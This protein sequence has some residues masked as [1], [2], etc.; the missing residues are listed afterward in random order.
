MLSDSAF[1]GPLPLSRVA[2]LELLDR[3]DDFDATG[4]TFL[5][6]VMIPVEERI[7]EYRFAGASRSLAE[8]VRR[9]EEFGDAI[10]L[11]QPESPRGLLRMLLEDNPDEGYDSE[12]AYPRE[13][14][15][16]L[17]EPHRLVLCVQYGAPY[18]D[19]GACVVEVPTLAGSAYDGRPPE[20][21]F[22]EEWREGTIEWVLEEGVKRFGPVPPEVEVAI[23]A[24]ER[25]E[26]WGGW[27]R[28]WA[29]FGGW[30]DL[31]AGV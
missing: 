15:I 12:Y 17:A 18:D 16:D 21:E 31:M 23:R 9:I 8:A 10:A 30:Q 20:T 6:F 24:E 5:T 28:R 7:G 22:P 27:Q 2:A 1:P 13:A 14:P 19:L 25:Q 4:G 3:L 26:V 11:N 29:D